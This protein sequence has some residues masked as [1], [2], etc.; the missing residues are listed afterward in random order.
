[1]R[2]IRGLAGGAARQSHDTV[3]VVDLLSPWVHEAL[4]VRRTRGRFFA[5][6]MVLA[7]LLAG[8][9]SV[10]HLR[11]THARS[12]LTDA[13]ADT[14]RLQA[15]AQELAPVSAYVSTVAQRKALVAQTMA[16]D[17]SLS[18]VVR[19]VR[20]VAPVDAHLDSVVI[21]VTPPVA[22][23]VPAAGADAAVAPSSLVESPC[24]GPDPFNTKTVVG[25]VTLAGTAASRASVGQF[26]IALGHDDLFVEPF[27]STTTTGEGTQVTFTGSVGLS[28]RI[29]TQKY[30]KIDDLLAARAVP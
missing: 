4:A 19:D 12:V 26:V 3:P 2:S 8:A 22:T 20:S 14:Q 24:P 7:V 13:Q 5:A 6:T 23:G 11:V 17:V 9:W 25:C 1:M 29:Y 15:A 30:V 28:Q 21:T 18:R 10:Q 27:I 16:G